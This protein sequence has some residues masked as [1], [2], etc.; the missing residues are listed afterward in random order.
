MDH[1]PGS[2][3][4]RYRIVRKASLGLLVLVTI[5][6]VPPWFRALVPDP[7]LNRLILRSLLATQAIHVVLLVTLPVAF[8][9]LG[10]ALWRARSRGVRCPA[11]VRGFVL[12][13]SLMFSLIAAE[14]IAAG[15]LAWTQVSTPRLPTRFPDAPADGAAGLAENTDDHA[16]LPTRFADIAGD[17]PLDIVVLGESSACGYPYHDWLSMGHIVAW[18][19]REAI[20]NRRFRLEVLARLGSR[21]DMVDDM[22][23]GLERRPDLVILYV[24]HNEFDSRYNWNRTPLHYDDQTL[25]ARVELERSAYEYSPLARLIQQ[26]IGIYRVS[27]PPSSRVT[28]PFVD[29]PAYT[30]AEYAERLY[31]FRTRLEAIT[32]YCERLGALVVLVPPPGNDADFEPNRSSLPLQ[33]TRAE[34]VQFAREFE[35]ASRAAQADPVRGIAAYRA[36]LA[37]QPGFAE[38]HY[39]LARLLEATGRREEANQH[40]VA[41]RDCDGFP[42]RCMSDFLNVYHEVAARHPHAILVDAPA[43]LRKLSPRGTLGGELFADGHHPSLIGYT[44]LSRT[45]LQE[46]FDRR[47]FGWPAPSPASVVTPADCAAHFEMDTEKW[48]SVCKTISEFYSLCMPIR[49]DPSQRIAR[50]D[51]YREAMRSIKNGLSPAMV[52]LPGIGT[53]AS[54]TEATP[55]KNREDRPDF[56]IGFA[57]RHTNSH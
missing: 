51:L 16:P 52:H 48:A 6:L 43:V 44:A 10:V 50:A 54:A 33:T 37:R 39:R 31:D 23:S 13:V 38:T 5:S 45:I 15:W 20:P 49:F 42:I 3:R 19:L 41:A 12:C 34:R 53:G 18:K 25:P 57:S 36:L 27:E 30:P 40:Y 35:A 17:E 55:R 1:G 28:R 47:A 32:A 56:G 14:G 26:T 7:L 4:D 21:L 9:A 24:G 11:L 29:V 46:L 8:S 22:M 2:A